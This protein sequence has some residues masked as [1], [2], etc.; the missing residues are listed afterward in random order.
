MKKIE[1]CVINPHEWCIA[2]NKETYGMMCLCW[3]G[4]KACFLSTNIQQNQFDEQS[5]VENT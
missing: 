4:A 2:G 3:E 1:I 5:E